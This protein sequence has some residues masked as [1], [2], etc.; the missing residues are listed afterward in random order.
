MQVAFLFFIK[1]YR[2]WIMWHQP[3]VMVVPIL[4]TLG[5]LST[6][7]SAQLELT[8][9]QANVPQAV[10]LTSLAKFPSLYANRSYPLALSLLSLSL[11][12]NALVTGLIIYKILTVYREI[13][14]L[15]S[16]VELGREIVP[17]ISILIESGVITFVVQLV[18][19]LLYKFD[20]SAYPLLG[21]VVVQLY[22]RD[23]IVHC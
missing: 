20:V 22:V 12:G 13:R 5:F 23:F 9:F 17:I 14:G 21:G 2:C 8:Y 18:Q 15:E 1:I 3:W 4:L 10:S 16:G 19:I 11:A 7:Q 6:F